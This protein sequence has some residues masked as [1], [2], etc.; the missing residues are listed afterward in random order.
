MEEVPVSIVS[1]DFAGTLW[2]ATF[3]MTYKVFQ[4]SSGEILLIDRQPIIFSFPVL[5]I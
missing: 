1:C 3:L 2:R 4:G 5:E